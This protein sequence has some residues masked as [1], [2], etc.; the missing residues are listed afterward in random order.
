M[1]RCAV[2]IGGPPANASRASSARE[3]GKD[4][5]GFELPVSDD[6]GVGGEGRRGGDD[7]A[8]GEEAGDESG[9]AEG[10][11]FDDAAGF[12]PALAGAAVP[13]LCSR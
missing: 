6:V 7:G 13:D 8:S 10:G 5:G 2:T 9:E 1:T 11:D 4:G 3:G 12:V